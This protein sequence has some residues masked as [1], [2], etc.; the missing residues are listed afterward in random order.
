MTKAVELTKTGMIALM[1]RKLLKVFFLLGLKIV[2]L[3]YSPYVWYMNPGCVFLKQSMKSHDVT[4]IIYYP[5]RFFSHKL[6]KHNMYLNFLF[7]IVSLPEI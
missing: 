5:E 6:R 3:E 2:E 7:C 1:I 4:N